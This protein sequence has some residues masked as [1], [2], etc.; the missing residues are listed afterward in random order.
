MYKG[1][2]AFILTW[3]EYHAYIY[4]INM[5]IIY[6][7]MQSVY[8]YNQC[9]ECD[10]VSKDSQRS[11]GWVAWLFVTPRLRYATKYN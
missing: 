8:N 10:M 6:K 2:I 11:S 5:C 7:D 9:V 3:Y 1:L 4:I